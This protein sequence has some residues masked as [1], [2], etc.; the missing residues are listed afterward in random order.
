[1][2]VRTPTAV[3][4]CA[5]A[6]LL[7]ACAGPPP[8]V[9]D[10]LKVGANESLVLTAAAKGVQIYECRAGKEAGA[11]DEWAL[12]APEAEL[13]DARGNRIGQHGAGPHWQALDGSR[14]V[15]TA[16]ARA[17]APNPDAIPWVLLAA[18]P[19]GPNGSFSTITSVQRINTVGGKAP[20]TAC[21]RSSYGA[22]V[23]V[24]YS[25]DYL[26]YSAR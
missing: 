8:A 26:F 9:P 12:V 6:C 13:F 2:R 20:A 18:R 22:T 16:K 25:A 21:S 14:T 23:R 15:G 3:I 1:M 17:D 11:P 7:S 19:D 24:P 4:G 10:A 5:V